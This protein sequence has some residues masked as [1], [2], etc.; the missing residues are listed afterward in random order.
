MA[1]FKRTRPKAHEREGYV[2]PGPPSQYRPE[3]CQRIIDYMGKGHTLT[4]FAG[5]IDVD[6]Q[7]VYRWISKYPE[8]SEAAD[9]AKA[10]QVCPWEEKLITA[11]KGGEVAAAI[12]ALKNAAQMNGARCAMPASITTF[13]SKPSLM[14]SSRPSHQVIAQPMSALSMF[15]TTV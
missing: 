13:A 1:H 3:Y 6:K 15:S 2:R 8:F 12:F 14:N 5:S 4:A 11:D 9:R 7:T 10:K